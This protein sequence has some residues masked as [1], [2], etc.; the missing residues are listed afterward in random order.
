[1]DSLGFHLSITQSMTNNDCNVVVF[2]TADTNNSY[3]CAKKN[4]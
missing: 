1:M 4:I 2:Y 3:L